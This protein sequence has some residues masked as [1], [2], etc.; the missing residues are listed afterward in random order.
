MIVGAFYLHSTLPNS[1]AW[2]NLEKQL[3]FDHFLW[4]FLT[5][6]TYKWGRNWMTCNFLRVCS[7]VRVC[8]LLIFAL[9]LPSK[10]Y[11]PFY[12]FAY[13]NVKFTPWRWHHSENLAQWFTLTNFHI[14]F[15]N[16]IGFAVAT[17]EIAELAPF[18][19]DSKL[20]IFK[21]K[22][23]MNDLQFGRKWNYAFGLSKEHTIMLGLSMLV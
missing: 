16:L 2:G 18:F 10:K 5:P 7:L 8:L 22:T 1:N 23:D 9:R 6:K 20:L 12:P 14:D 3:N 11:N 17:W 19:K 21:E 15:K 13:F 4:H